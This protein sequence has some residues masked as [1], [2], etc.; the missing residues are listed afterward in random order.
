VVGIPTITNRVEAVARAKPPIITPPFNGNAIVGLAPEECKRWCIR[1]MPLQLSTGG[2]I[3]VNSNCDDA[4]FFNN[5]SSAQLTAPAAIRRRH[6]I[7]PRCDQ[8]PFW[9]HKL[10]CSTH[11]DTG[12]SESN[13]FR[14]CDEKQQCSQPWQRGG[15]FPACR[16][17]TFEIPVFTAWAEI[18]A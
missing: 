8:H 4:A 15:E 13:L 2:G 11:P 3:F 7:Q 9:M 10:G 12:I 18:S 5:S 16:S 1:E 14:T 6:H 17:D